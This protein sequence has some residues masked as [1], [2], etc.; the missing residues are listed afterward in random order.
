MLFLRCGY[1]FN[2]WPAPDDLIRTPL[3]YEKRKTMYYD[4]IIFVW[5]S[6]IQC[7]I[8]NILKHQIVPMAYHRRDSCSTTAPPVGSRVW[9]VSR[10][11]VLPASVPGVPLDR[12]ALFVLCTTMSFL[13]RRR[14]PLR[15]FPAAHFAVPGVCARIFYR[16][17]VVVSSRCFRHPSGRTLCHPSAILNFVCSTTLSRFSVYGWSK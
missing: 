17:S 6:V 4:H 11:P 9:P 12:P 5:F 1:I 3:V 8:R 2:D 10:P 14:R 16:V 13:L 15:F 7:N